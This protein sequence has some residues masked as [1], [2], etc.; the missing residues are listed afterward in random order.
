MPAASL[1]AKVTAT[2]SMTNHE[3]RLA[4]KA[5]KAAA[6]GVNGPDPKPTPGQPRRT[7][8]RGKKYAFSHTEAP[9]LVVPRDPQATQP[10]T[11]DIPR[12]EGQEGMISPNYTTFLDPTY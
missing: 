12:L 3:R 5:A 1:F 10:K 11:T 6:K 8:L 9:R 7:G 4:K 2:T